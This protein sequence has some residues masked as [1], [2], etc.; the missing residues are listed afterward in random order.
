MEKYYLQQ[1]LSSII[2]LG[3]KKA[4]ILETEL[5]LKTIGDLLYHIPY[6]YIDRSRIY[7]IKELNNELPEVQILGTIRNIYTEGVGRKKRLK[8]DIED[9]TGEVEMVWFNSLQYISSRYKIGD[10]HLVFGKFKYYNSSLTISHPETTP[11]DRAKEVM[12][13]FMPFYHTTEKMKR[14]YL[15]SSNLRPILQIICNAIHTNIEETLPLFVREYYQLMPLAQAIKEVHFPKSSQTLKQA[16]DRLKFD[17]LFY[18][19][20]Y[21]QKKKSDRKLKFKGNIF[22][23]VGK[24]FHNLLNSLPYEL[25]NA[26]KKVLRE[27]RQD[28]ITG[29]QMNRLVQGD[30]GCG[31]TLVALFAMLLAID[32]DFQACMMAPTEIL[33]HQ[34]YE[35]ISEL[36]A[37]LGINIALLTGSS[38]QKERKQILEDLASGKLSILIGTH[39]LIEDKVAF[40]NLGI[41]IIDEQHRFGVMQRAKL[42]EKNT[43]ILPHILIMSAT[44]IPRTLSLSLFGDLDVSI[45]DELPPGRKAIKT[46][47]LHQNRYLE[48]HTFL[49]AE[50]KKGRQAYV[51]FPMI[52]GNEDSDYKN[53]ETGY[54]YY[55]DFFGP[56]NVQ[57][58]HGKLK[59]L[60]K[61]Q[62]MNDFISGKV[63]ILLSTTVIEV[64]VNVPNASVMLIEDADRFGLAQLHQLRGRVGRGSEKSYCLLLTKSK[65][66][67]IAQQRMD[68]MC[69]TNDGFIIAEED[70]KLRGAGDVEGLQQ[71][72]SIKELKL[73]DPLKDSQIL[74]AS[75]TMTQNLLKADP[76]LQN[77]EHQIFLKTLKRIYPQDKQWGNIG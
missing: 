49:E 13:G 45:I 31:K 44:P 5:N 62:R 16:K 56:E 74:H 34:H 20:L 38:K 18:F 36:L 19:Q 61:Q 40:S 28:T 51:V 73:A 33:A 21:R 42:W 50:I 27:I 70:M 41:A 57:W 1:P 58:V 48:A 2:R 55:A 23:N 11:L 8:I 35:S 43:T 4:K 47:H 14:A 25:T 72:G 66:N 71:S 32:N 12:G 46:V 54:S 3:E 76:E 77:P 6:K 53:L 39:A 10:I 29:F 15:D 9:E 75:H 26:Q 37:P 68:V 52:E 7:K 67:P 24:N 30:V 69:R 17:E 60:E 22:K 59:P 65:L 64:G 63:P